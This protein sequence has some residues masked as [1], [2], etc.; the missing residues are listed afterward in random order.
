[1]PSAGDATA[2]VVA[3][4]RHLHAGAY[5]Q[6]EIEDLIG[7]GLESLYADNPHALR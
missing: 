5:E 6:G 2:A 7:Q 1:M 4:Q 3:V